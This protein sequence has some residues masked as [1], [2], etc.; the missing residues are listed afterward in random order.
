MTQLC[1]AIRLRGVVMEDFINYRFP[2]MFLI[3][4]FCDWKCC[5][6]GGFSETICQNNDIIKQPIKEFNNETLFNKYISNDISKS[7]VVGGLEPLK[8]FD[9]LYCLIKYFRNNKCFDT[10]VIYTGFKEDEISKQTKLL[11]EFGNIIVKFGR[12]VPNQ[13]PHYD[14]ILGVY[15][16]SDNQYAKMI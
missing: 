2:S 12:Y 3:T 7:I 16:A 15:L 11:K 9:E 6:E 14:E 13:N 1:N 4:S 8:Q 5:H 10:F